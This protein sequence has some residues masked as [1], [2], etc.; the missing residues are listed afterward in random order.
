MLVIRERQMKV[1]REVALRRFVDQMARHIETTFPERARAL[2]DEGT[3]RLVGDGIARAG[4]YGIRS[5]RSVALFI[6]LMVLLGEEFDCDDTHAWM[7]PVLEHSRVPDGAKLDEILRQLP[8]RAP[9]VRLPAAL[10]PRGGT[11]SLA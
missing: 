4:A 5:E 2:G 7:R 1:F 11:E 8:E 10:A 3:R 9:E 6:D